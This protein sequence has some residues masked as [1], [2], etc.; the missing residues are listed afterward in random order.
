MALA[1]RA[2]REGDGA[3]AELTGRLARAAAEA[4]ADIDDGGDAPSSSCSAQVARAAAQLAAQHGGVLACAGA[5]VVT[6]DAAMRAPAAALGAAATALVRHTF[7]STH[8]DSDAAH[9]DADATR[10]AAALS[11]ATA[12]FDAAVTRARM[13]L[14]YE[15]AGLPPDAA[16]RTEAALAVYGPPLG[17]YCALF[18]LRA[19]AAEA[20]AAA[21]EV[22]V[23]LTGT[24]MPSAPAPAAA[25]S[26]ASAPAPHGL[27]ARAVAFF[28]AW[29]L[30]PSRGRIVYALKLTASACAA[31]AA[32]AAL[33]G[34]GLWATLAVAFIGP[35]A[36]SAAAGG[37]FRIASLRVGGTVLGALWGYAVAAAT[38]GVAAA[39]PAPA[40]AL[41]ALWVLLAG[42]VRHSPGHAY[43]AVVAQFTPY[44]TADVPRRSDSAG[45]DSGGLDVAAARAWAYRRIEQNIVGVLIF[46]AVE[47]CVAPRRGGA[48]LRDEIASGLRAAARA[49]G[50][51][52]AGARGRGDSAHAACCAACGA[53]CGDGD[54]ADA[55]ARAHVGALRAGLARQRALLSE[56]ADEPPWP[57]LP[58]LRGSA[59]PPPLP[60]RACGAL[61]ELQAQ[62]LTLL[63]LLSALLAATDAAASS[64]GGDAGAPDA[65]AEAAARLV[66][67]CTPALRAL[68]LRLR[69]RYEALRAELLVAD[70]AALLTSSAAAGCTAAAAA[71]ASGELEARNSAAFVALLRAHRAD[72]APVVPSALILPFHA[73][74]WAARALARHADALAQGVR[75]A[76]LPDEAAAA[77]QAKEEEEAEEEGWACAAAAGSV[78]V[79]V[80]EAEA[81]GDGAAAWGTAAACEV[82]GA[83]AAC[84]RV[85]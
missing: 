47:L 49:A 14:F 85:A 67:P 41:L 70:S 78:S 36:P 27:R 53:P 61:L 20:A 66:A 32:G 26:P 9:D 13:T 35:R 74:V 76:T 10:L 38:G 18:C 7:R 58:A 77:A 75:E 46:A 80:A 42:F 5:Q 21:A 3:R 6:L 2:V 16:A 59:P 40:L 31:A 37:S 52:A 73:L 72:G 81:E 39:A 44:V 4:S 15:R 17:R 45:A 24:P 11:A 79:G 50:A 57:A 12:A 28:R 51:V 65:A 48:A 63:R 83:A 60:L 8:D 1:A 62:L 82:C 43:G 71:A 19:F 69:G 23:V 34:S 54:A 55:D 22:S 33:C 56:A 25:H 29:G 84:E 64:P 68:L 30:P